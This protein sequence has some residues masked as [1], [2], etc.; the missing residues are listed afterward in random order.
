M[1][2]KEFNSTGIYVALLAILCFSRNVFFPD[3][4]LSR[5]S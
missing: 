4:M 3:I 5:Y 1:L 2:F